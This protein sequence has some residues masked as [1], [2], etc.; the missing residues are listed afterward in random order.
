MQT[1]LIPAP[2]KI[3][4]PLPNPLAGYV[5]DVF[6]GLYACIELRFVWASLSSN[7]YID[8]RHGMRESQGVCVFVSCRIVQLEYV[9]G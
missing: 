4:E 2:G 6:F 7:Q 5:D 9:S 8:P 3:K 1:T